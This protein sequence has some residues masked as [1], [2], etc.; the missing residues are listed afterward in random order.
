MPNT[1]Q[2]WTNYA[3]WKINLELIDPEVTAM[4]ESGETYETTQDL[5]EHL[6]SMIDDLEELAFEDVSDKNELCLTFKSYAHNFIEDVNW[7]EIAESIVKDNPQ[8]IKGD[9]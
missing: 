6:E 9:S 2:G 5:A 3:T 4:L 1:Y 8:L 7:Y